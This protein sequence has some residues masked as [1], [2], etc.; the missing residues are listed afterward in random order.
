VFRL[1]VKPGHPN[2]HFRRSGCGWLI[3]IRPPERFAHPGWVFVVRR[4]IR[5]GEP[6]QHGINARINLASEDDVRMSTNHHGKVRVEAS[7]VQSHQ[8]SS[9]PGCVCWKEGPFPCGRR[10]SSLDDCPGFV[11]AEALATA[12][13]P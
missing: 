3:Q 13:G 7:I 11:E 6:R 2:A 4:L 10:C 9:T 1:Y 8:L 12:V 5:L